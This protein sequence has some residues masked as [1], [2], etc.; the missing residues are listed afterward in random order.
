MNKQG[1]VFYFNIMIVLI[2]GI[3]VASCTSPATKHNNQGVTFSE[4]GNY[5]QAIIEYNEAIEIEPDNSVFYYNRGH[6]YKEIIEYDKAIPDFTRAIELDP[7]FFDPYLDRGIV[8]LD[9]AEDPQDKYL[10]LAMSDFDIAIMLKPNDEYAYFFRGH[11]KA[12][13]GGINLA[14]FDWRTCIELSDSAGN[15][16]LKKLAEQAIE[17]NTR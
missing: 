9:L 7:D 12:R 14:L 2:M 1:L 16:Y 3:F 8:F 10:N 15:D 17:S 4:A 5:R 6:A 13:K 11:C